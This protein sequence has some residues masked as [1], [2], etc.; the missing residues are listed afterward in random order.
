MD[1]TRHEWLLILDADERCTPALR[2][3]I[4]ALFENGEPQPEAYTIKRRVFFLGEVIRFSGWQHDRVV[5]LLKRGAGRYP[6]RRVHADMVTRS[7][8]PVLKN[9]LEHHMVEDF[10][11]YAQRIQK[12]SWWGAAQAWRD[13]KRSGFNEVFGRSVWRFVRTYGVQLGVLDGMRG[14]VFCLLQAYGTYLKWSYLWS[15]QL[16]QAQGVEP[17]LPVFDENEET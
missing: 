14:L 9:P 8:A 15:W 11:S 16:N 10:V 2:R 1:Q 17:K 5:R 13:G 12:Y 3:E 6:N 7:K 4:C